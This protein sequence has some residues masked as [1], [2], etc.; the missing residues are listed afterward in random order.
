MEASA[1]VLDVAFGA[2]LYVGHEGNP[3]AR[4]SF[5]CATSRVELLHRHPCHRNTRSSRSCLLEQIWTVNQVMRFFE[6][7]SIWIFSGSEG[8]MQAN[9]AALDA[10]LLLSRRLFD[11]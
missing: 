3:A 5:T 2:H 9:A 8:R 10:A 6:W 7:A 1:A 11:R 4:G